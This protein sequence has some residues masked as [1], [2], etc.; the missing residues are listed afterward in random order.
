MT[1]G[2]LDIHAHINML[3]TTPEETITLAKKNG[4]T[5]I[6]TIGTTPDDLPLVYGLAHKYAP[7]VYCTLGIHPHDANLF[8]EQAA[9]FIRSKANDPVVVGVGEIGL[10]FFYNNSDQKT[11]IEVFEKQMELAFELN[12][13]VEI[14]TRDAEKETAEILKK[15]AGRVKGLLHCFTSSQ[16][17][18]DRA[19]ESDFDISISGIVTFKNADALRDVVRNIPIER[20]HVE[21][22]APFLAP[23]PQRGKKN[24]PAFVCHTGEFVAQ[25]KSI[26][27]NEF[28]NHMRRNAQRVFPKLQLS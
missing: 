8:N 7:F 11:Q 12:L 24:Q 5:K 16:W 19:L 14:H 15:Y 26:P 20:L 22:D 9:Q 27:V 2:W 28:I 6:F 21:T 3:D 18:A 23:V 25:L 10:D 17:L 13:P 4:V 1:D